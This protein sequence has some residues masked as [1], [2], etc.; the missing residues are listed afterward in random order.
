VLNRKDAGATTLLLSHV[1]YWESDELPRVLS[2]A[3][4]SA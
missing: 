2:E 4:L 3:L 1:E